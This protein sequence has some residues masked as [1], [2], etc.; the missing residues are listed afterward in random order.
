MEEPLY[1]EY[2][3]SILNKIKV[4]KDD[5]KNA[6]PTKVQLKTEGYEAETKSKVRCDSFSKILYAGRPKQDMNLSKINLNRSTN[7]KN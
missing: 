6:S 1:I 4:D 5:S 3:S 2:F 7:N